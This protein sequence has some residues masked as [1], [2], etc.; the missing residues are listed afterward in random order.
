MSWALF[1]VLVNNIVQR[2]PTEGKETSSK[3]EKE[4][5]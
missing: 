4:E 5:E 3:E 2:L 1:W